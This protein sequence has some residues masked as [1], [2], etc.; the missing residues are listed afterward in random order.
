LEGSKNA[1]NRERLLRLFG[2]C[3]RIHGEGSLLPEEMLFSLLLLVWA[4]A[5]MGLGSGEP[6]KGPKAFAFSRELRGALDVNLADLNIKRSTREIVTGLL[7][8]FP[9]AE[10]CGRDGKWPKWLQKKSYFRDVS[11]FHALC[12]EADGGEVVQTSFAKKE[13]KKEQRR[14]PPR[15]R[16]GG[17]RSSRQPA[18]AKGGIFGL[19]K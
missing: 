5:E 9:I 13:K 19:K 7:V 10:Q 12:Q 18:F 2:V 4:E 1:A 15:K 11:Q 17:R 6:L 3:D 14:R 8:N 16:S